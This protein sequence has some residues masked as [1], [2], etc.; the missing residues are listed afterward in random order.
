MAKQKT[1]KR[2]SH[3]E[4]EESCCSGHHAHCE[5]AVRVGYALGI[6]NA[7][8]LA[9]LSLAAMTGSYGIA[10]VNLLGM[11]IFPGYEASWAGVFFGLFWGF[12]KGFLAGF[13]FMTIYSHFGCCKK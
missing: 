7:L 1:Q 13:V 3:K 12:V 4:K 2:E 9:F 11:S 8:C 10:L 6:T 5:K